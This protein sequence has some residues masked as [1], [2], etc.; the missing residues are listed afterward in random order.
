MTAWRAFSRVANRCPCTQAVFNRP[1]KLSVGAL[2]Q[3]LPL[4]DIELRM[5]Q[6]VSVSWKSWLQY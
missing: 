4:R 6:A 1:H 2:S 5:P 3:Q